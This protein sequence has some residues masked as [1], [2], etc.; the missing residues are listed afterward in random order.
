MKTAGFAVQPGRRGCEKLVRAHAVVMYEME[1]AKPAMKPAALFL[2]SGDVLA[3]RRYERAKAYAAE[4]DRAAAADLLMQALERTP[5]FA[6]GWFM[7]GEIRAEGGDRAGA[8]EAFRAALAADPSDRH[9]AALHLARLAAADPAA[10]MTPGYVRSLFDQYAEHF[11]QAL[12]EGLGY[13]G[14]GLLREAL[15]LA[16]AARRRPFRFAR[17]I[18]LGCGTGFVAKA[19]RDCC[20]TI[21]GVDLSPAMAAM[22][23]RKGVYA[24]VV[25]GDLTDFLAAQPEGSCDL[26]VAG[27]AFVYLADLGPVC[28]A[29]VRALAADGLFAFTVET[30]ADNGVVLGN[31]LRYA[32]GA[33]H[34]RTALA[35]AGLAPIALESASTRNEN[36][37]AV[38]GLIVIAG[39]NA[40]PNQ[41]R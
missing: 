32:H 5:A 27:D 15:R 4:G 17:A 31:K 19:L 1:L 25:V 39:H 34:V 10:A 14:P 20:D 33:A 8:I 38:P 40:S 35:A 3:D 12:V 37:V 41:P 9:G 18:D 21:L 13:R 2:S 22:A 36:G 6:S 30:H 24:D 26:V 29:V 28:R 11:D 16:C 7:L 23:R